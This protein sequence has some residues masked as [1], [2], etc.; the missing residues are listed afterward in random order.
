LGHVLG[1]ASIERKYF[2]IWNGRPPIRCVLPEKEW[3]TARLQPNGERAIPMTEGNQSEAPMKTN[4]VPPFAV[5]R[6]KSLDLRKLSDRIIQL[7]GQYSKRIRSIDRFAD[8]VR[9]STHAANY[10]AKAIVAESDRAALERE[11]DAIDLFEGVISSRCP[12]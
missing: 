9:S 2:R 3:G 5:R 11:Y 4:T 8:G 7:R 6:S 1:S 12:G 10:N